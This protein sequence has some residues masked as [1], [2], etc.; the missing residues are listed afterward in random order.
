M[1]NLP[2]FYLVTKAVLAVPRRGGRSRQEAVT[3][4]I[5]ARRSLFQSSSYVDLFEKVR[6]EHNVAESKKRGKP[7]ADDEGRRLKAVARLVDA[8]LVSKACSR[9][10]SR[11]VADF[12][13][14]NVE[15]GRELF[16]LSQGSPISARK[17]GAC[18]TGSGAGQS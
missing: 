10:G 14:A 1:E 6:L 5:K 15:K 9:L 11:G 8:G 16:P 3:R 17:T 4:L 2:V 13:E 7:G 18:R 12:N